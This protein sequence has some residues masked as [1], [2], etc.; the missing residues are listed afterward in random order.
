MAAET[1]PEVVLSDLGLP[2]IDGYELARRLRAEPAFG[3][4]VLVALSGYGRSED[5]R[6][7]LE[8]GFDHHLVKPP[9]LARLAELLGRVAASALEGRPPTLH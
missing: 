2:G 4:V 6:R 5:Q 9:D 8:A 1:R 3:K 7:A